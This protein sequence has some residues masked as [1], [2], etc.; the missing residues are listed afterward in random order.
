MSPP[1]SPKIFIFCVISNIGESL[2][3]FVVSIFLGHSQNFYTPFSIQLIQQYPFSKLLQNFPQI[4]NLSFLEFPIPCK[5]ARTNLQK[6]KYGLTYLHWKEWCWSWSSNSLAT[7]CE[8]PIHWKTLT[9]G[10]IEGKR[11]R[12]WQRMK[13]LDDITDSMGMS[14][15]K[16]QEIMKDRE[17]WQPAA[18]SP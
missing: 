1:P 7:S 15:S 8:E 10:K 11:R 9:L 4:S 12:E 5:T 14:L 18:C 13:W 6:N 3:P 16:L 17:A 2:L